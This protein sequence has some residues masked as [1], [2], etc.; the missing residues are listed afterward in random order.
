[1]NN[2]KEIISGVKECTKWWIGKRRKKL[3]DKMKETMSIN[4]FLMPFLYDYHNL[5][6]LEGLVDLKITSHLMTGHN[7]GFGK[8]I[9]EKILPSV[10]GAKKLD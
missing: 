9:D 3:E 2:Q 6:S 4:P 7:T 10:F 5:N 1:M 8:F